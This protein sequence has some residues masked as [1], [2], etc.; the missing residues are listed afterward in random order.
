MAEPGG[1]HINFKLGGQ[2]IIKNVIKILPRSSQYGLEN[3]AANGSNKGP[4][5]GHKS[6]QFENKLSNKGE[7]K[8][9]RGN[10]WAEREF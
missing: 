2:Q 3:R 7:E 5:K 4:E 9:N 1:D 10:K 8:L 6:K